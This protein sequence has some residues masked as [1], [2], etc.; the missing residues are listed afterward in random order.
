[1]TNR[2]VNWI[3]RASFLGATIWR[4]D[5]FD[6]VER[7]YSHLTPVQQNN[8]AESSIAATPAHLQWALALVT[9]GQSTR[10]PEATQ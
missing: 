10:T 3:K 1:M 8:L 6:F 7:R 2:V 9:S 4:Q 5:I